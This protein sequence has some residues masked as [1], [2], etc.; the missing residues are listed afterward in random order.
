MKQGSLWYLKACASSPKAKGEEG[1]KIPLPGD[2]LTARTVTKEKRRTIQ[3]LGFAEGRNLALAQRKQLA[4]LIPTVLQS[5]LEADTPWFL[6]DDCP[7]TI[8]W[9]VQHAKNWLEALADT[10]HLTAVYIVTAENRLFKA[11]KEQLEDTLGHSYWWKKRKSGPCLLASRR[12]WTISSWI[13]CNRQ[14]Y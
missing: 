5:K 1:E 9:D 3:Q 14:K 10:E 13:S 4:A 2:Y 7:A 12:I 8:L 11:P 6:D